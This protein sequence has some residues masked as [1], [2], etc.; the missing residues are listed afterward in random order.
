M[1][2]GLTRALHATGAI[3]RGV[4][5]QAVGAGFN[6][7][8]DSL[9][10]CGIVVGNIGDDRVQVRPG[11]FTPDQLQRGFRSS[12]IFCAS[13]MTAPCA[14][15]ACESDSEAATLALSQRS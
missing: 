1:D 12:M 13:A 11:R 6:R 14:E 10:G 5:R 2:H 8:L 9:R 3:H 4:V 15:G 7:V